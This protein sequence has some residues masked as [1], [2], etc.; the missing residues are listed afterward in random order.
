[1]KRCYMKINAILFFVF[2]FNIPFSTLA[3]QSLNMNSLC[4]EKETIYFSCTLEN[5][6]IVSL[7]GD[8]DNSSSPS[9]GYVQYRFG[10]QSNKEMIYPKNRRPPLNTFFKTDNSGGSVTTSNEIYFNVGEYKYILGYAMVN[11][12]YLAVVKGKE[13]QQIFFKRC[14]TKYPIIEIPQKTSRFEQR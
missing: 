3:S 7:C 4:N 2:I 11:N 10:S 8:G 12:G 13:E 9:S 14:N 6:K 1:M 5:K